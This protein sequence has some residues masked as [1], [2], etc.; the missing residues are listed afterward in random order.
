M[1]AIEPKDRPTFD[2]IVY[3]LR[4]NPEFISDSINKDEFE[5]YVNY[6]D[7]FQS[8]K[9]SRIQLSDFFK[10]KNQ[11][12]RKVEIDLKSIR[13]PTKLNFSINM[14][15]ISLDSYEKVD[16]IGSGSFG[17]VYKVL[18]KETREQY[19]AKVSIFEMDQCQN[20][21]IIN[22]SR[23]INIISRLKHPS[24]IEFIGFSPRNF[25]NKPKPTIITEFASNCS[26]DVIIENERNGFGNYNWND[27]KK[28]IN[29][30]GIASG[31]AYLHNLNILHRDLKPGNILLDD[32]LYP[33]IADFGLSRII[34][35]EDEF[36]NRFNTFVSSGFKGTYAYCAPEIIEKQLYS[37]AGD[38]YA[39]AMIV[40][41]I[42]T[43]S[44]PF[45]GYNQ[46]RL[47]IDVLNNVR[48]KFDFQIPYCYRRLIEKC[49]S[50][51]YID[52]PEFSEIV[53]LLETDRSFITPNIDEDEYLDY[54]ELVK[55]SQQKCTINIKNLNNNNNENIQDNQIKK[56]SPDKSHEKTKIIETEDEFIDNSIFLNLNVFER[57]DIICK[58]D[59][60]KLYKF[61]NTET[62]QIF[63]GQMSMNKINR[64]S[65]SDI[66]QLSIELEKISKLNHPCLLK[67]VGY[68]PIDFKKQPKPVIVTEHFT[69]GSLSNILEIERIDKA[70]FQVWNLTKKLINI[71]GIASAMSY[72]HSQGILHKSLK[73]SNIYLDEVLTPKI[74]DFGLSTRFDASESITVQSISGAKAS[75]V[76]SAP[77]ILLN[78]EFSKSSDVYA[79]AF[80]VFEIVSNE[81]P[82]A[83]ITNNNQIFKEVVVN[84]NRPI[85]KES[86]PMSYRNL[87]KRCWSQ[88]PS[89]RPSFDEIVYLLKMDSGFICDNVDAGD[90]QKFIDFV[91]S[92]IQQTTQQKIDEIEHIEEVLK[93]EQN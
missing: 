21:S 14:G 60:S 40:Y 92:K 8:N 54:I 36:E 80:V 52:R 23:E 76:Y 86:I 18:D 12:F 64:L 63:I 93:E 47:L 32:F 4:T 2:E 59:L 61:E 13:N 28:L 15:S 71:Y 87:I 53:K 81:V 83:D 89:E 73:T 77:E 17:V 6:I 66:G 37:K 48:P 7:E 3:Y 9:G 78:N 20:D 29:V 88:N 74:G 75:P 70:N 82:F 72:L 39:F 65:K 68:S 44:T 34:T 41:E 16:K 46:F 45:K 50:N 67:F 19:A 11:T 62:G 5:S 57:K 33:K 38:V 51:S 49:W 26:L 91:E 22:L 10:S 24:I 69:N 25:K 1:L 56:E 79:F 58:S 55:E 30:Y 43:N 27:T 85:L 42:M 84:Q 31:M 90:Y 35:D